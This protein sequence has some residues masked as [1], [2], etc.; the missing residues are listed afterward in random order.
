MHPMVIARSLKHSPD[1]SKEYATGEVRRMAGKGSR[2][3]FYVYYF[4]MNADIG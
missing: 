4:S 3:I 2:I 1:L